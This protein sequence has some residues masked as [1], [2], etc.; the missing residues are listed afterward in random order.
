MLRSLLDKLP[1]LNLRDLQ[2]REGYYYSWWFL[3]IL[4]SRT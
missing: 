1:Y 4:C 3:E 2:V